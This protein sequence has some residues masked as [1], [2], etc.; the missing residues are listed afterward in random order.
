M[1]HQALESLLTPSDAQ[2]MQDEATARGAW[3]VWIVST[4]DLE[5]PGKV[6]ARA[7]AVNHQGGNVLPG[8][9][10]ADTLDDLRA[11]LPANLTR[12]NRTSSMPPDVIEEWN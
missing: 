5:H 7:H 2:T 8:A 4:A 11:M 9:L 10:V 1:M 6:V 3:L 12:H